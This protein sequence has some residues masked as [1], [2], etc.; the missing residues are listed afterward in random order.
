MHTR[1]RLALGAVAAALV[2]VLAVAAV[3]L[4][5]QRAAERARDA[6]ARAAA[7]DLAAALEAGDLTAARYAGTA[8]TAEDSAAVLGGLGGLT[9]AVQVGAVTRTDAAARADLTLTWPV[10]TGAGWSYPV[11]AALAPLD[12]REP[13][14][15]W[16]AEPSPALVH[17]DLQQGDRLV[18]E[19]TAAPRGRVL[20]RAGA[21]LVADAPVVEV[22]VQP[23]RATD[24]PAL[25]ARLGEL[26]GVDAAGLAQRVAAAD[27]E[28]FVPV[29][30]LR[31]T[32]YEP[33]RDRL[34]PLPGTVFREATLPLAPTREFARALL[35]TVGPAS[36]EVVE[37]SGGRVRAGDTTGLSGLQRELDA[38]LA[39]TPGSVVRRVPE[40]GEPTE[41]FAEPPVAGTD[42]EL[43]LDPRVQQ[44]ADA[45]LAQAV[46]AGA[47]GNG[48]ASLVAVDVPTGG[49]LAV[50]NT[51]ATG[52]DRA[53]TGRYPPG[54]TFKAVSTLALLGTG[55]SPAEVVPCPPTATVTGR[56][57][58]NFEGGAAGDVPFA[59]DFAQS[60]N[61][62]FVGLSQRLDA[63]ALADAGASVGLGG[64][65]SLGTEAFT[66]S[67]PAGG[68]PVDVAAA[69]IGQGEVLASPAAMAV[70]VSTIARG[71]WADPHLVTA[72]EPDAEPDAAEGAAPAPDPERLRVVRDLMREV[73]VS[74]TAAALADVPGAP[75][76]AKT[77]TAEHGTESPPRTHAWTV[78]FQGDVAFAVLVEDGVSGGRVAVPVAEA[79][80]RGLAG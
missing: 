6:A 62:A 78:G 77:G 44:A 2:L 18:A 61:T 38:H 23:S 34:Q 51:P 19:R 36:E 67:V 60:C 52:A 66:G 15:A 63:A 33:L 12:P 64:T 68:A 53:L 10:G 41:L 9:P 72:P 74:G 30:T 45:A 79:F 73:A 3:V 43:T 14:G 56:A 4:V 76:H 57:F 7:A 31:R 24:V 42:A 71:S 28:A 22:G 80:L 16:G 25:A 49:V 26:T 48:N 21:P 58:Q 8:P 47:A 11:T 32:D 50:A 17:P 1:S 39:G 75:V 59:T 37:A 5:R 20:G 65:W 46:A 35:G 54:S 69:T 13:E 55:L 27:P 70:A 29:I 40:G